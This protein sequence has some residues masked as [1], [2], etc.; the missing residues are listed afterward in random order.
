MNIY[1]NMFDTFQYTYHTIQNFGGRKL[2]QNG[3]L[4]ELVD[5][6]LANAQIQPKI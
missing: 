6:A 2:W 5:N 1:D 4:Q 3:S